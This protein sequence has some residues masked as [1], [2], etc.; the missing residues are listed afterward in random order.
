[1]HGLGQVLDADDGRDLER[2]GEDR[3]V[4][5]DTAGREDDAA[6]VLV[7]DER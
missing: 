7:L 1:V 5:G 4:G 2:L 3:G 6:E